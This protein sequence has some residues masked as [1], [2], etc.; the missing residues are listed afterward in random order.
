MNRQLILPFLLALLSLFGY[1][2]SPEPDTTK[3]AVVDE[4]SVLYWPDK[5]ATPEFLFNTAITNGYYSPTAHTSDW[6]R[7]NYYD[8]RYRCF[9]D[10]NQDGHDDLIISEPTM[11]R[12]SGG[13]SYGVYLWT[14]GNYRAIASI[15]CHPATL[16]VEHIDETRRVVWTYWHSS[17]CSG[18]ISA[19]R[20]SSQNNVDE[21]RIFVDLGYDGQEPQTVGHELY[22]AIRRRATVPI[23]TE[24]SCTTNGV[25]RWRPFNMAN[26][27]R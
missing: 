1:A 3:A 15:G 10:L 14:N 20:V 25:V 23:R 4:L 18:T 27:Y 16:R 21:S 11:Q 22:D 7:A 5:I 26:E 19:L 6:R 17:G 13:L 9:V 8:E 24:I 12:G 2:D